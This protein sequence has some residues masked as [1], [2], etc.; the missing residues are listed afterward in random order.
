MPP[1]RQGQGNQCP[2]CQLIANPS[3]LKV[4]GETE[5]FYAWLDINPRAKGYTMVVPKEHKDSIEEFSA[6]EYQEAMTLTR[7]VVE[8]AKK[9]LG[10]DGVSVTMNIDESAGQ[11]VPHAYIQVFP[12]FEDEETAG[13]P[14]GAVFQPHEEAK[15]NLDSIKEKMAA[16]DSSFGETS[17]EP[18]PD[19][20][21]F[22]DDSPSRDRESSKTDNSEE[23]S[24]TEVKNRKSGSQ[25]EAID[26]LAGQLDGS[27]GSPLSL[28]GGSSSGSQQTENSGEESAEE[29][30]KKGEEDKDEV[31]LDEDFEAKSFD[32]H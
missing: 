20:Q 31:R 8:K 19:S 16:V 32:W 28:G 14:T 1:Q 12:R 5:N 30:E 13:T 17:K 2:F 25:G 23:S 6:S 21:N 22:K 26:Q 10:A 27:G 7:K 29:S 3:Q 4:V 18:H 11:M 15:K 24:E 9:G